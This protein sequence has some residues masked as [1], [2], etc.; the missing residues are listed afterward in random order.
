VH[1]VEKVLILRLDALGDTIVTIPLIREV[2]RCYPEVFLAVVATTRGAPSL[3]GLDAIDRLILFDPP[4]ASLKDYLELAKNLKKEHFDCAINVSEKLWAYLFPWLGSVPLRIGFTPGFTQP[5]KALL[6]K[7]L[8]THRTLY[9]NNPAYSSGEHEV[10]RQR[11]LLLHL[12]IHGTAGPLFIHVDDGS[13]RDAREILRRYGFPEQSRIIACHLSGKWKDDGYDAGA[14]ERII[15][16]ATEEFPDAVFLLTY[17]EMERSWARDLSQKLESPRVFAYFDAAFARWAAMVKCASVLVTM[18]TSASHLGAA[19]GVPVVDVFPERHY[20]H[21]SER[22][23]PWKVPYRL[24]KRK[25]LVI[26]GPDSRREAYEAELCR[27]VNNSIRE[28]IS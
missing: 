26:A 22:W 12:G 7:M 3:E 10:E 1:R 27:A 18:D 21:C 25:S 28:L 24:V 4:N 9:H 17:G 5:V 6:C 19:L 15:M 2:K 23:Y 13:V 16:S 8:L 14:I 20:M 11:R